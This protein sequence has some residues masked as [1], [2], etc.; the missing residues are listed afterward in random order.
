MFPQVGKIFPDYIWFAGVFTFTIG[1]FAG[2]K[3]WASFELRSTVDV[4]TLIKVRITG[5]VKG[6]GSV[7]GSSM[8]Q[9]AEQAGGRL[10]GELGFG[11]GGQV[12]D[13]TGRR[14]K[15]QAGKR[16]RCKMFRRSRKWQDPEVAS[17]DRGRREL[18]KPARWWDRGL[19]WGQKI[20]CMDDAILQ[21][22]FYRFCISKQSTKYDG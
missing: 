12:G 15:T 18:L 13:R 10:N 4:S 3:A 16:S 11:P 17:W 7:D 21:F 19:S 5:L 8:E 6:S 2:R 9:V 14:A 1:L 20:E 22:Q